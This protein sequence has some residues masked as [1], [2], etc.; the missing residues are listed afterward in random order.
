MYYNWIVSI[1]LLYIALNGTPNI[2]CYWVG[3]VPKYYHYLYAP[4]R[5]AGTRPGLPDR[6]RLRSC[7]ELR[8]VVVTMQLML[9]NSSDINSSNISSSNTN[10]SDIDS[11]N[12]NDSDIRSSNTK[13][14]NNS[15]N[16][17][18]SS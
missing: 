2:D 1:L 3:A 10:K 6:V 9:E 12:T 8:Q 5:A 17:K 18:A 15:D 13:S 11:S 16:E 4:G 14:S 7:Q